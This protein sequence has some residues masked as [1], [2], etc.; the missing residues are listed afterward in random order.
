MS[1]FQE[2]VFQDMHRVFLNPEEFGERRTIRYDGQEYP[3]IPVVLTRPKEQSRQQLQS[4]HA[5]GL[6][7]V[8]AVL[9]CAQADLGGTLPEK[10]QRIQV[11]D[12][13][14]AFFREY[15]VA[16]SSCELGMLHLELE[17]LDE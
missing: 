15:Y 6:Y 7:L 9:H 14:S 10:G 3:D 2:M 5:Q 17:E 8:T 1:G 13:E 12:L 11:S 16:S 4:D